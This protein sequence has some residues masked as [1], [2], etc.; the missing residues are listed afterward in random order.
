MP[1]FKYPI[2]IPQVHHSLQQS[3]S[4]SLLLGAVILNLSSTSLTILMLP[5]SQIRVTPWT[6]VTYVKD[7]CILPFSILPN[8]MA[9][10]STTPMPEAPAPMTQPIPPEAVRAMA[11]DAGH[12]DPEAPC[13]HGKTAM[14]TDVEVTGQYLLTVV[15]D[16]NE[17]WS[18]PEWVTFCVTRIMCLF[19]LFGGT[20]VL[21]L[22]QVNP[23]AKLMATILAPAAGFKLIENGTATVSNKRHGP[24]NGNG[25][26][27]GK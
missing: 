13:Y 8:R 7:G 10:L 16:S 14:K 2:L 24:N 20:W 17:R 25:N 22:P 27:K 4:E 26:G 15:D 9:T 6:W 19:L 1:P 11:I 5:T 3:H 18:R 21:L 12:G 23:D